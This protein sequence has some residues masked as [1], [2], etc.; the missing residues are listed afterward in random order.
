MV[1]FTDVSRLKQAE[2]EAAAAR[3][4]AETIVDTV[5][6]PLVVLDADLNILSANSAFCTVFDL[7]RT[8]LWDEGCATLGAPFS[9]MRS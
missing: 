3:K 4:Y 1:T 7:A 8:A 2:L 6:D 9:R 5:Q